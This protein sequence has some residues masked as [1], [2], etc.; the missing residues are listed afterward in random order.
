MDVKK[1]NIEKVTLK[2]DQEIELVK[3]DSQFIIENLPNEKCKKEKAE[4][5]AKN[6]SGIRFDDFLESSNSK[7]R[8]LKFNKDVK[9]QLKNKLI[10]NVSLAK[11][12]EDY[13]V[14]LNALVN[15]VP[16]RIVVHQNDG[17][18]KYKHIEDMVKAQGTA[19][20]VNREKGSW[21]YK[22][23]KSVYEKIAKDSK[24]FM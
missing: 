24:F 20:K 13:F 22:V 17:K 7:V 10:Y 19:Q 14:R 23:D 1:D 16:D 2:T 12:K 6:F 18:E 3:K 5:Y 8:S 4:E 15:E 21:V 9:I 11:D